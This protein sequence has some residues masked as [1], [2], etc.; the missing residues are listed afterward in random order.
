M[1]FYR[2]KAVVFDGYYLRIEHGEML[3][4]I[5][6]AFTEFEERWMRALKL[7]QARRELKKYAKRVVEIA[8]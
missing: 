4:A 1:R 7:Q 8:R 3:F 2:R 5:N 6:V